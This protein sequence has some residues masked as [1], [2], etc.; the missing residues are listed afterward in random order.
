VSR[1][2]PD[3]ETPAAPRRR[4]HRGEGEVTQWPRGLVAYVPSGPEDGVPSPDEDRV[5]NRVHLA[6]RLL[7]LRRARGEPVDLEIG[8]LR[9]AQAALSAGDRVRALELLDRVLAALGD[10]A[11]SGPP[12]TP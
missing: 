11:G 12:A 5:A 10:P 7:A 4:V 2:V 3:G 9:A 1:A 8:R 6:A